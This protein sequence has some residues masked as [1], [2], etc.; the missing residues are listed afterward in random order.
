MRRAGESS[1]KDTVLI[2][3]IELFERPELRKTS[4]KVTG[5]IDK[6][7]SVSTAWFLSKEED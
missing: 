6:L 3:G 7:N 4:A 2:P 1:E 5:Q